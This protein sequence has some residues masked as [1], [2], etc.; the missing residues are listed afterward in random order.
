[1]LFVYHLALKLQERSEIWYSREC[2]FHETVVDCSKRSVD[3]Q[4]I[5][6][7][8][9][10]VIITIGRVSRHCADG[11]GTCAPRRPGKPLH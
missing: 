6:L 4:E 11:S 1:M 2:G 10:A 9:S 8:A 5:P 3:S 7:A